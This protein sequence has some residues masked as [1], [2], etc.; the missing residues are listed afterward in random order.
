MEE[1][2]RPRRRP[3]QQ[4]SRE[5][6]A[7]ILSCAREVL[8]TQGF[9]SFTFDEVAK[10]AEVPIGTLYQFFANKYVLICELDRCDAEAITAELEKFS[11]RVPTLQWPEFLDEFIDH[12]ADLW[13]KDPSRRAVWLAVQSTPATR[14]TAADTEQQL[15]LM[16]A[17]V[18]KP[19]N[20]RAEEKQRMETASILLHTVFS[21]LNYGVEGHLEFTVEE[22]KKMLLAYLFSVA[23]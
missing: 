7:R 1:I 19:L 3:S 17:H 2:L 10:R 13:A 12:L 11:Q 22:L 21:L 16:I 8:V 14:L 18:L 5:R 6:Y 9:E 20:P 4:R 23:G 15:L